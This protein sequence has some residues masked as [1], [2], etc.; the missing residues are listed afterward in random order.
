MPRCRVFACAF[1]G[2]PAANDQLVVFRGHFEVVI[3]ETRHRERNSK[4]FT[5]VVAA[6]ALDVVRRIAVAG[7]RDALQRLF[8]RV[9]TKQQGA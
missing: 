2:L 3:A 7:L 5:A 6:D 9:E 1:L 8:H 4:L